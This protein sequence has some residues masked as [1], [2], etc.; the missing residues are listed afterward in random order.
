MKFRPAKKKDFEE[1]MR[2]YEQL[3]SP[4]KIVPKNIKKLKSA[5]HKILKADYDYELVLEEKGKLVGHVTLR[6]IP[7]FWLKG[8]MGMIDDVVIDQNYRGQGLAK[9]M[10]KELEQIAKKK[11]VKTLILYTETHR[12]EAIKLYERLKYQKLDKIWYKKEL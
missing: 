12:P 5:W 10:M 3:W 4:G 9:K 1:I 2:L 6:I 7:E 11:K 8:K